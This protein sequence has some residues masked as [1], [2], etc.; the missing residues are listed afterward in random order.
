MGMATVTDKA[1]T[2]ERLLGFFNDRP[3]VVLAYL[4]GSLARGNTGPLSDV[5]VAVKFSDQVRDRFGERL[6]I[7]D[8]LCRHL[9]TD[10]IDLVDLDEASPVLRFNVVRDGIV[11]K[12]TDQLRVPFEVKAMAEYFD[13]EH[14]R[15]PHDAALRATVR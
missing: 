2:R 11:L 14:L 12:D 1:S 5:D 7:H 15:L 6:S 9:G 8:A 13:T 10:R 4:F 3:G